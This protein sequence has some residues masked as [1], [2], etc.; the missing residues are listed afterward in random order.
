MV[1]SITVHLRS[2]PDETSISKIKA[3]LVEASRIYSSDHETLSWFV[4][5]STSDPQ[6]FTIIERYK[7]EDSQKFHLENPYWKTFDP[8]V[9]PLLEKPMDL[10]RSVELENSRGEEDLLEG[11]MVQGKDFMG[12]VQEYQAKCKSG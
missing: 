4:S 2:L 6:D 8:F 7:N 9:K 10:R 1:Y 5:Q 3:K 12:K 11:D